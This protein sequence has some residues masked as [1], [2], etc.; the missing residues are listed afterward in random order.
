MFESSWTAVYVANSWRFINVAWGSPRGR[1]GPMGE[2]LGPA[3]VRPGQRDEFY[4]LTDPEEHIF[5]HMPY[6]KRWQLMKRPIT[7]EQF[8]NLPVLKSSFFNANLSLK[9]RYSGSLVTKEGRVT[10]RLVMPRFVGITCSLE[11]RADMSE[12]KGLTLVRVMG[13]EVAILATPSQPGRFYLNIFISSPDDWKDTT[14]TLAASFQVSRE[15]TR[16]PPHLNCRR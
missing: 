14:R 5:E 12:L 8:M 11:N 10:V 13:E 15:M 1:V 6:Q 4:F 2:T 7:L 16:P 3:G 9:K